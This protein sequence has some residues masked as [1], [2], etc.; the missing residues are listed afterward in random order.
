MRQYFMSMGRE[1]VCIQELEKGYFFYR[2]RR[3]RGE[4]EQLCSVGYSKVINN[5]ILILLWNYFEL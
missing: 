3:E 2:D 4:G 1:R 5:I